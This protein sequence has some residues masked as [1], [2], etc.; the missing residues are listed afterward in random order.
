MLK[1]HLATDHNRTPQEYRQRWVCRK[2]TRWWRRPTL[3]GAGFTLSSALI[4]RSSAT[5]PPGDHTL[6]DRRPSGMHRVIDAVLALLH[7]DLRRA[8]DPDHRHP[9]GE[10]GQPLLQL[11]AIVVRGGLLDLRL[12]LT[13]PALDLCSPSRS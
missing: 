6:L 13:D 2:T 9:A 10:L 12:D 4:A 11:L 8:A 1:R 5:P 3:P 7:L